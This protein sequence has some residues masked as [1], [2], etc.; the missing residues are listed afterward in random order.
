MREMIFDKHLTFAEIIERLRGLEN[1]I[2]AL[3]RRA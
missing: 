1:E 3:S 2:N